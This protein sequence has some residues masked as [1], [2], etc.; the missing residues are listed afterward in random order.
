MSLAPMANSEYSPYKV[1]NIIDKV[2]GGDSFATGLIFA[3]TEKGLTGNSKQVLSNALSFAIT[4]SCLSHS[5]PG[6]YNFT[7]KSKIIKLMEGDSSGRV[8]R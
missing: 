3:L 1:Q 6:D 7:Q 2:G 4:S 5:I 8:Q